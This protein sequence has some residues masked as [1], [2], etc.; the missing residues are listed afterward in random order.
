MS[1]KI[2]FFSVVEPE[3]HNFDGAGLQ[4]YAVPAP[5]APA[6]VQHR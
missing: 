4:Q 3:P 1:R 6:D 5:T 2:V